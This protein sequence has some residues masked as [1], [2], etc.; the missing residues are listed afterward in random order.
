MPET[1]LQLLEQARTA[2]KQPKSEEQAD[3]GNYPKGKVK[4]TSFLSDRIMPLLEELLVMKHKKLVDFC[5][6]TEAAKKFV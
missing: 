1:V 5:T 2:T 6:V 3:A 4:P